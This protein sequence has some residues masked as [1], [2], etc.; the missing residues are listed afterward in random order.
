M[1]GKNA[2]ISM[3]LDGCKKRN[4][5]TEVMTVPK[6]AAGNWKGMVTHIF[7]VSYYLQGHETGSEVNAGD[8]MTLL[9]AKPGSSSL[10]VTVSFSI[11]FYVCFFCFVCFFLHFVITGC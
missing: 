10:E 6:S 2:E 11:V 1:R 4:V 8:K 3:S 5:G 7:T 9:N